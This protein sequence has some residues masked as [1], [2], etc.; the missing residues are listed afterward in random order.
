MERKYP[1]ISSIIFRGMQRNKFLRLRVIRISAKWLTGN[2]KID[3]SNGTNKP[4]YYYILLLDSKNCMVYMTLTFVIFN[5]KKC[6][7]NQKTAVILEQ[8]RIKCK[9]IPWINL[10]CSMLY[11]GY[12]C[13]ILNVLWNQFINWSPCNFIRKV[14]CILTIST[15]FILLIMFTEFNFKSSVIYR[16]SDLRDFKNI[17]SVRREV[18]HLSVNRFS[19]SISFITKSIGRIT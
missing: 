1:S 17:L 3:S 18:R 14:P 8:L 2:R 15:P 13:I 11:Q 10:W 6:L 16:S 4:L 12:P 7:T 5:D 9:F 19:N